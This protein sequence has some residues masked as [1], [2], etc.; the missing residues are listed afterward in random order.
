MDLLKSD[1]RRYRPKHVAYQINEPSQ[2]Q[3]HRGS[4]IRIHLP[5]TN[6]E[7]LPIPL[8]CYVKFRATLSSKSIYLLKMS[9]RLFLR[10]RSNFESSVP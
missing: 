2:Y 1:R 5:W 8:I 9:E 7:L 6:Y 10:I 3:A 4:G